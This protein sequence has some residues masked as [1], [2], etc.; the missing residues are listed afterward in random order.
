MLLVDI[1]SICKI[2]LLL[3]NKIWSLTF[4]LIFDCVKVKLSNT[5]HITMTSHS[6]CR[7][8]I[9]VSL[10]IFALLM[11]VLAPSN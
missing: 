1:K 4:V 2:I 3:M 5:V 9:L 8:Y 11:K 7:G 6:G 10:N